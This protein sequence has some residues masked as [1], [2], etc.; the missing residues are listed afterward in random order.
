MGM[1]ESFCIIYKFYL[2]VYELMEKNLYCKVN[3]FVLKLI[4]KFLFF[5]FSCV[6]VV[7]NFCCLVLVCFNCVFSFVFNF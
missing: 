6:F 4:F 5:D 1:L 7:N 2:I 3:I